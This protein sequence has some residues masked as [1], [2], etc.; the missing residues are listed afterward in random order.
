MDWHVL[1]K[2]SAIDRLIEQYRVII[3]VV[4]TYA[5]SFVNGEALVE[6]Y[7]RESYVDKHGHKISWV[8]CPEIR[9]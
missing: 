9:W 3:D 2:I 1:R 6:R 7:D 8:E 4:F 5:E